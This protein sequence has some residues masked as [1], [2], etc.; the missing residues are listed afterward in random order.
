MPRN[1]KQSAGPTSVPCDECG[2]GRETAPGALT[3]DAD[4][5]G[6]DTEVRGAIVQPAQRCVAVLESGGEGVF[7][8]EPVFRGDD[9]RAELAG[10]LG[11]EG[12]LHVDRPED[13]ATPV[14]VEQRGPPGRGHRVGR[15]VH[16][17]RNRAVF[18]GHVVVGHVDTGG[19]DVLVE[20]ADQVGDPGPG[21]V[22][23][24]EVAG[25]Q[26]L[27]EGREFGIECVGHA[28]TVPRGN[29]RADQRV[30]APPAASRSSGRSSADNIARKSAA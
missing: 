7:R 27:H 21:R 6:V 2:R 20:R 22:D 17:H 11:R 1:W 3:A 5:L 12:V 4:P 24:G 18:E 16:P 8:C 15:C 28:D 10:D 30:G 25:G 9:D 13:E 23:I 14:E 29:P 26:E 19:V